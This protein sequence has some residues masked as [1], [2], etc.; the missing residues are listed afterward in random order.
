MKMDK[1]A[2]NSHQQLRYLVINNDSDSSECNIN[3]SDVM[4][5]ISSAGFSSQSNLQYNCA[6]PNHS[7]ISLMDL[8]TSPSTLYSNQFELPQMHLQPSENISA[9]AVTSI[10]HDR[11][12]NILVGEN[13]KIIE[14]LKSKHPTNNELPSVSKIESH[15]E[16][17]P[18]RSDN[19]ASLTPENSQFL[20]NNINY[21][22]EDCQLLGI[23]RGV[24]I[25]GQKSH[26]FIDLTKFNGSEAKIIEAINA[27]SKIKSI[28]DKLNVSQSHS[29][30]L[31][32]I[33]GTAG[34][35]YCSSVNR[36]HHIKIAV[37]PESLK[38]VQQ[39]L[40]ASNHNQLNTTNVPGQLVNNKIRQLR[41]SCQCASDCNKKIPET[42]REAIFKEY[43]ELDTAQQSEYINKIVTRKQRIVKKGE[44]TL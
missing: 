20:G 37:P 40:K 33:S 15:E 5:G 16:S 35:A 24:E 21:K 31:E 1:D 25:S 36:E 7:D 8:C 13:N 41:I 29:G 10:C 42:S 28:D 39:H 2:T 12:N 22:L 11:S 6:T 30:N 27:I 19:E 17:V 9:N 34:Q 44:L 4:D 23:F 14:Q 3:S 18:A 26:L 32:T 43:W 38:K